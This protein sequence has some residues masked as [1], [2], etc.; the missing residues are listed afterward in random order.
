MVNW[1]N[2]VGKVDRARVALITGGASGIGQAFAKRLAEG[3]SDIVVV[4]VKDAD[5]TLKLVRAY[6]GRSLAIAC[7]ITDPKQVAAMRD[8]VMAEFGRVDILVNNAGRYPVKSFTEI[9]WEDWR[10]LMALNLD[11]VFLL[12]KAFA[13]SMIENGWGRIVNVASNTFGLSV[14]GMSHYI[15]SKGGVIGFTRGL[16]SDL[17]VHG[18]T[19]NTLA[20]GLTRTASVLA[21]GGGSSGRSQDEEFTQVAQAQAVKRTLVPEDMVGMLSYLVSEGSSVFTGQTVYVDGGLVRA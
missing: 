6:G 2:I 19:V 21:R 18:I 14:G 7:D 16:A 13:P 17:G 10:T 4:D 5:E 9:S 12:C 15:A 3:G 20:P 8:K 11:A 1:R